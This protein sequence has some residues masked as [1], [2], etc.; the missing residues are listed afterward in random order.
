MP[1]IEVKVPVEA[2]EAM[3][4]LADEAGISLSAVVN[5]LIQRELAIEMTE[6][7]GGSITIFPDGTYRSYGPDGAPLSVGDGLADFAKKVRRG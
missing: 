4:L 7:M 3:Q 5:Y 2:V 1:R 6:R